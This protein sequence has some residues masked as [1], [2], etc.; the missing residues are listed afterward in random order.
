M[1][2]N[3]IYFSKDLRESIYHFKK[4]DYEF[5]IRICSKSLFNKNMFNNESEL[6]EYSI[7]FISEKGIEFLILMLHVINSQIK[8]QKNLIYIFIKQLIFYIK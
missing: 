3:N 7:Q 8:T 1:I 6:F 2:D 5:F 4:L